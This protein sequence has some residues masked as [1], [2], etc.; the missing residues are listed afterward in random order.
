MKIMQISAEHTNKLCNITTGVVVQKIT[1]AGELEPEYYLVAT[2][3]ILGKDKFLINLD[4]GIRISY[5][6]SSRMKILPDACIV[7]DPIDRN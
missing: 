4:T 7:L 3:G 6:N 5:H 1:S 2:D